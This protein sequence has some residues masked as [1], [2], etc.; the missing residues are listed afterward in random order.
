MKAY[1]ANIWILQ[2]ADDSKTD[3]AAS[4]AADFLSE[5]LGSADGVLDWA[6][7]KKGDG[8]YAF[9]ELVEVEVAPGEGGYLEGDFLPLLDARRPLVVVITDDDGN[10][11]SSTFGDVDVE[12]IDWTP[13]TQYG[14]GDEAA[15]EYLDRIRDEVLPKIKGRVSRSFYGECLQTYED[16]R[17]QFPDPEPEEVSPVPVETPTEELVRAAKVML[18]TPHINKYLETYDP[19][20][21]R[22]LSE[23]L[24]KA[25]GGTGCRQKDLTRS[26]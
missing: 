3:D 19:M 9:P 11:N 13:C 18:L 1:L 17:E 7:A 23:A 22:Q 15:R 25:E 20:A 2:E 4:D 24:G 10:T 16:Y 26:R 5:F 6:Y 12:D 21:L 8:T 14:D